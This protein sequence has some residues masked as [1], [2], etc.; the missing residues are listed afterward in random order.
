M[1]NNINTIKIHLDTKEFSDC[2][3]KC[4]VVEFLFPHTKAITYPTIP[5]QEI[6]AVL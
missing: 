5:Q 1:H 6:T 3:R 4:F 2:F